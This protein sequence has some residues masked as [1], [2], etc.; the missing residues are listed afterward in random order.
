MSQTLDHF[1]RHHAATTP[2]KVF[3]RQVSETG[4]SETTYAAFHQRAISFAN[5]YLDRGAQPGQVVLIFLP[6]Q[7]DGVA[8]FFG[9]MLV[10]LVPAFM[11]CPS[12]KQHASVYWPA[13]S[14][15]MAR[16]KPHLLVTDRIN[17]AQMQAHGITGQ[18]GILTIDAA[19][20]HH[21]PLPPVSIAPETVALLQHSSGTTSLKKGVALS[22]RA[23]L[24]QV[25]SYSRRLRMEADDNIVTWLP[26]YHDMGLIACTVTPMVLGQTITALSP[27]E[28]VARPASLFEAIDRFQGHFCWLPN[29]AFE[30]LARVVPRDCGA[31]LSGM[32]AFIDCSEPCKPDTF[33]RFAERFAGNGVRANQLQVCYAMA[34]TVFAVSQTL[35]GDATPTVTVDANQLYTSN[36]VAA[37]ADGGPSVRLLSA[38]PAVDGMT[39]DIMANGVVLADGKVGEIVLSSPFLFDGYFKDPGTTAER[40]RDGRYFTRDRGFL[41]EGQLFVLGRL[42]DLLIING[43]NLHAHEIESLVG[44]IPG[45]KSGRAVAFGVFNDSIGSEELVVVAERDPEHPP[46]GIKLLTKRVRKLIYEETNIEVHA[47]RIVEP[48]WLVKTT[49]GKIS[50]QANHAKYLAERVAAIPG[51]DQADDAG[52]SIAERVAIVI[53]NAFGFPWMDVR[54]ETTADDVEGWDSLAHASLILKVEQTFGIRFDDGEIFKLANV[55]QLIDRVEQL[56]AS[57]GGGAVAADRVVYKTEA[58]SV[59]RLRGEDGP[60]V[61]IFAGSETVPG[62]MDM[63]SFSSTFANFNGGRA[64][65]YFVT[66]RTLDWYISCFDELATVLNNLSD[67]PKLLFGNSMGGY[68]ALRFANVLTNVQGVL[69]LVART[70]PPARALPRRRVRRP[71]GYRAALK[72]GVPYCMLY[73]SDGDFRSCDEVR[74]M[75]REHGQTH[76]MVVPNCG[77]NLVRYLNR[78]DMLPSLVECLAK[79]QTMGS[80]IERMLADIVPEWHD[81]DWLTEKFHEANATRDGRLTREQSHR[82]LVVERNFSSLDPTDRGFVTL[83]DV[84]AKRLS[85]A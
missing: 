12:A 72:P 14:A 32:R 23:I 79:P 81:P 18:T 16:I 33:T 29:F 41:L 44:T 60:D 3:W 67:R 1:V 54:R 42:D 35:V 82:L 13:H 85:L 8:A 66:N 63:M 11:P 68:A 19:G 7:M 51:K 71:E 38:G 34:E 55:G 45:L 76:V 4:V 56:H 58:A 57:A 39:V 62:D 64:T 49:S 47:C 65:K 61:I 10:G 46:P 30:H 17:A 36:R 24:R 21:R 22:H 6:Q 59:V 20:D 26:V 31:D 70:A 25:Q 84:L 9:A 2:D 74:E 28:W 77:H 75:A 78:R 52:R 53:A 43:R 80:E 50:R 73:G 15:L 69:T 40:L 83:E 5:H 27:F 37:P 48:G